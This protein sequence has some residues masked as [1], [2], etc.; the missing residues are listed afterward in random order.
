MDP[1]TFILALKAAAYVLSIAYW[2]IRI[3]LLF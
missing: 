2:A 1:I 3:Y